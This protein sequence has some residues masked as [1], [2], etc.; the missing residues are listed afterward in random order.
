M[1]DRR[2]S[3]ALA[4]ALTAPVL[5]G[6]DEPLDEETDAASF[7]PGTGSGGIYLNTNRTLE[8]LWSELDVTGAWHDGVRLAGVQVPRDK[9]ATTFLTLDQVWSS[10]GELRGRIGATNYG[11]AQ[12][13][14]SRWKLQIEDPNL[15][16]TTLTLTVQGY[17]YDPALQLHKYSFQYLNPVTK[18]NE[19]TCS[20][21]DL[22]DQYRAVVYENITVDTDSGKI[23][24][25]PSTIY[26][27]CISGAVGKAA[28][29]N[30]KP[31]D[32]A[33]GVEGFTAAVRS[34]RAD[35]CG[36]GFS[37]TKPGNALQ[38]KDVW[39]KHDFVDPKLDTEAIWTPSGAACLYSPRWDTEFKYDDVTCA[40]EHVKMCAPED[41]LGSF[42]G[43]VIWSKRAP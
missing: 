20:E 38:L 9:S 37:W 11:G 1:L 34:V 33:L 22:A 8:V 25:R 41:G 15:G 30:Y 13:L 21:T 4:L 36:D 35:Y 40:G 27:A 28:T 31:Y 32:P 29:W 3:L 23:G 2:T 39:G 16:V 26:F 14:G 17:S 24:K 42:A 12:F 10:K 5:A 43:A 7:R 19:P 18:Q 6:C